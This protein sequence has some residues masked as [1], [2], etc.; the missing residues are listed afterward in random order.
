[1]EPL[2]LSVH[3]DS[4]NTGLDALIARFLSSHDVKEVSRDGYRRRLRQFFRWCIGNGVHQPD[5]ETV[6]AYKRHLTERGFTPH[7]ESGYLVAV[8]MFFTWTESVKLYPNIARG[9]RG[10]RKQRGF[11]RDP[12]TLD[13]VQELL[14][15]IESTTLKGMRDRA[16]IQLMIQTGPRTIEVSRAN[17]EDVRQESGQTVLWLQGKGADSKD[18]FVVL[19]GG[20]LRPLMQY[21]SA[22]GSP[23][24]GEPLFGSTSDG[25]MH[26][27][28]TTKSIRRIV[29]QRL[30]AVHLNSPRLSAHSL[31]HT[32]VTFAL[33]AGA[34]VQEA[35]QLARHADINTTMIYA[36][37]IDRSEGVPEKLIDTFLQSEK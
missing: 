31:R 34:S 20:A 29:K 6:L 21:L 36:H 14:R 5:R 1:M 3:P 17:I 33:L 37:N 28:M 2:L 25:N 11:R 26:K 15:S 24:N 13:Q 4:P 16:M 19:T 22:R 10:S 32:T 35:Q 27:R 18:A 12:L 30:R 23:K 8:R 9:I 7:S